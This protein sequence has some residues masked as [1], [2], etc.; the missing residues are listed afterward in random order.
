MSGVSPTEIKR[1]FMKSKTGLIGVLI[2]LSLVI[3]SVVAITTIPIDTFKQWNNPGNWISYPK[4]STPVWVNY[5]VMDKI[6]EHLILD[7]PTVVTKDDVIS[8]T[9]HQFDVQY[10]Y[11]DFPSDFI[12]EINVEYSGSQL[13][14]ISLIRPDNS[15]I[16]LVSKSLPQSDSKIT[17]HERIFSTDSN[18]KK[19]IQIHFS[20]MGFYNQNT[21]SENMIFGNNYGD[22][23]KGNYLFLVNIYGV[24]ENVNVID[25]KLILGGKAYGIMGTDELRRDL[26]V[27]LLWGTPLALFIGIAVAV[28]SVTVGLIYGVYAGFKGK[29]TDEAMMRFND[30]IYALPA[31]PFL[32]ILAVTI[33]NSIFLLVAF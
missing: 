14:Q 9:S 7:N 12:Y 21:T 31:L 10:H 16:L 15:Q 33:S 28:G 3:L 26:A 17:H 1:E 30:V 25:S 19:N 11:D 5:F 8:L 29:K 23:L 27:G 22:V 13:L 18:I 4:T 24:N 6:P 20:E 2:L 32:I